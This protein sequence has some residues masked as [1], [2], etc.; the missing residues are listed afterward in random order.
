MNTNDLLGFVQSSK[1][2]SDGAISGEILDELPINVM[3]CGRDLVIKYANRASINTLAGLAD[4]LP[5]KVKDIVG[6]K[7]DIF[8]KDPSYQQKILANPK[9]L[10]HRA[11]IKLGSEFLDLNVFATY[12]DGQYVGAM[13]SWSVA[14]EKLAADNKNAQYSSMLESMPINILMSDNDFNI[15]YANPMSFATLKT[16]EKLLPIPV[17]KL[18][19][20]SIDVFHKDP[21]HQRRLLSNPANLPHRAKIKLGEENLDLFVSAVLDE[22]QQYTGAMVIWEVTTAKLKKFTDMTDVLAQNA[23]GVAS[24]A[25]KVSTGAQALGATTEQM[26][27][28][29][30]ELTASINSI[31]HNANDTDAIAKGTQQ[32]A[33][34][35]F[36]EI[37]RAIEAMDSISK[38]SEDIAEIIKVISEIANQT[39]L[40]AF[41]AAIEAARAGEHGLGFSVVADEVRKLAERSS[42]ATE[43]ISKLITESIKRVQQGAETSQKA[44]EAF[45]GIAEGVRKTSKSIADIAV[46]SNEQLVAAKEVASAIEQV[47]E[48]AE[49]AAGA[50]DS[51]ATSV[52]ELNQGIE[53]LYQE[54]LKG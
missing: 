44:G 50:S 37:G 48:E 16:I 51:I 45:E 15:V 21:Q 29:V 42:Q 49:K 4:L 34:A 41:N 11:I 39:N 7:I 6:S 23:K 19:G 40:L 13:L 54:M 18:I 17:E 2:F 35:G 31:A 38:S 12:Q 30:E 32:Q 36:V 20:S 24:H 26:T 1:V 47:A 10:P 53:D 27:A 46:S 8:H 25:S 33:E 43:K 52:A 22:N 3:Y 9:N 14:T 28:A 5:V